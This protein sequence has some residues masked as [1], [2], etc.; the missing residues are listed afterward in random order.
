MRLH[1][2]LKKNQHQQLYRGEKS[3]PCSIY[4]DY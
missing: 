1:N 3:H 2:F 4:L